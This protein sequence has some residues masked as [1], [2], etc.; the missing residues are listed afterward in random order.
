MA[1]PRKIDAST[2]ERAVWMDHE[3]LAN[4]GCEGSRAHA[5]RFAIER[6]HGVPAQLDRGGI[7]RLFTGSTRDRASALA[8][9]SDCVVGQRAGLAECFLSFAGAV[10]LMHSQAHPRPEVGLPSCL[11]VPTAAFRTT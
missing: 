10:A 3:H 1:A 2:R 7:D 6:V 11:I 9:D 4:A 5:F 8:L